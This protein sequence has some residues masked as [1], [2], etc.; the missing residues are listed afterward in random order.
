MRSL[1]LTLSNLSTNLRLH[2]GLFLLLP[3]ITLGG[4]GLYPF[5][6]RAQAQTPSDGDGG[7][8]T[9]SADIQEANFELGILTARGN[10]RVN[11]PARQ[12]QATAAQAQYFDRERR[13]VLSGNVFVLQEGNSIRAETMTYLIDEGRFIATP[14]TNQ[15]VESTY[16][17]ADPDALTEPVII[18]PTP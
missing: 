3:A 4:I 15:Q 8:I 13:L 9:L 7:I 6:K 16:I 11:Y 5:E 10:V 2:L 17:V 14:K 1:S 18:S 12:I